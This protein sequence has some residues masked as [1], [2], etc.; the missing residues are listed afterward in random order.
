MT[1]IELR[2]ALQKL[3]DD[4]FGSAAVI[5]TEKYYVHD[6]NVG[7]RNYYDEMERSRDVKIEHFG[8]NSPVY[9]SYK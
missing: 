5:T 4:G 2:D 7:G 1:V 3:V 6:G 9:I 8:D